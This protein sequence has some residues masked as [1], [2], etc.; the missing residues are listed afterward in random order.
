MF[1]IMRVKNSKYLKK[2]KS[3]GEITGH[4]FDSGYL[5]VSYENINDALRLVKKESLS[6]Y[7]DFRGFFKK[8]VHNVRSKSGSL[9]RKIKVVIS[10]DKFDV[11]GF[12]K[13]VDKL[14]ETSE[15]IIEI[16]DYTC[17][18][19]TIEIIVI[20]DKTD[21]DI[22]KVRKRW[23][24]IRKLYP[25]IID[26]YRV[27]MCDSLYIYVEYGENEIEF[28]EFCYIFTIRADKIG[29]KLLRQREIINAKTKL[30]TN[31]LKF[32]FIIMKNSLRFK[33]PLSISFSC[34]FS[35][36]FSKFSPHNS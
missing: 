7:E 8:K 31:Y 26:V 14:F 2:C 21:F 32:S 9:H 5:Y 23:K 6:T 16:L 1:L 29:F 28:R 17:N 3:F 36:K 33:K 35:F 27:E 11:N 30:F 15:K 20:S 13:L 10:K 34:S 4:C 24:L 25:E 18:S 22:A 19:S 12:E